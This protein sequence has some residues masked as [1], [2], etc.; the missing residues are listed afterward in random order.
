MK[1]PR[2]VGRV[3]F[4]CGP[5]S[6]CTL[7]DREDG[8]LYQFQPQVMKGLQ[9]NLQTK[10]YGIYLQTATEDCSL[11]FVPLFLHLAVCWCWCLLLWYKAKPGGGCLLSLRPPSL[12]LCPFFPP[13]PM[14]CV[15]TTFRELAKYLSSAIFV[16]QMCVTALSCNLIP[17]ELLCNIFSAYSQI[18]AM[19]HLCLL[20]I[21]TRNQ[22]CCSIS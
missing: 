4:A 22:N 19:I 21:E 6:R 1:T 11:P 10:C 9:G 16:V 15:A 18:A 5:V 8:A 12:L 7:F 13:P 3:R 14:I 20:Q 17:S 2:C